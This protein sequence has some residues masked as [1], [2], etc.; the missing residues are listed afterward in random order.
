[1]PTDLLSGHGDEADLG[2]G[3]LA[4]VDPLVVDV[5]GLR[6][7][8]DRRLAKQGSKRYHST[9]MLEWMDKGAHLKVLETDVALDPA[10]VLGLFHLDLAGVLVVAEWAVEERV[11]GHDVLLL[12]PGGPLGLAAT[13]RGFLGVWNSGLGRTTPICK[14]GNL[15]LI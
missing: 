5:D 9:K 11:Q 6:E 2:V 1:M 3:R 14:V 12:G 7:D 13:H 15:L 8:V 10:C 4:S